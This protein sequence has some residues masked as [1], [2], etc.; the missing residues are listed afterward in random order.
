MLE[1]IQHMHPIYTTLIFDLSEVLVAG[2][3]GVEKS[4]SRQLNISEDTILHAFDNNDLQILFRNEISEEEY[5]ARL[6]SKHKWSISIELLKTEIRRNFRN[7][8]HGM[9]PILS[10]LLAENYNLVLLSDHVEEWVEYIL[11]IHSFVEEFFPNKFFSFEIGRTKSEKSTYEWVLGQL[12]KQSYECIFIDDKPKNI[13]LAKSI[14][15]K[16]IIFTNA[17]DLT[18]VIETMGLLPQ[19]KSREYEG[20][21]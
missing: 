4:L 6:I 3:Q 8:V 7:K 17:Q 5:L 15:I 10:S 1:D 16:G 20:N 12:N 13:L 9:E 21:K 19:G 11:P 18:Q 2:L 14:G